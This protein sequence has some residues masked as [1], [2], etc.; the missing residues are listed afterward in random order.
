M[1]E[2]MMTIVGNVVDTPRRRETKNGHVV[3]NF[4][5]ASTSR[6]YDREQD[7][8]IDNATLYV[9]VTCW[10]AMGVNVD[11]SIKKGQPVI[12]HGRYY[13]R[14]YKVDE[15]IRTAYELEAV[16]VGHD[17]SRGTA[18]FTRVYQSPRVVTVERD[19]QGLPA[20][21]SDRW[22]PVRDDAP[23]EQD[24]SGSEAGSDAERELAA[25]S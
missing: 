15:Q 24:A 12:V 6:R 14:E 19:P 7:K 3:T 21:E 5:I 11:S 18:E 4:R 1:N 2:T 16:A 23:G 20:D 22:L 8:F 13:M 10:R 25:V 9:T 17:L